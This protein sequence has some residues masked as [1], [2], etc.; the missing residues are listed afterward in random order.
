MLSASNLDIAEILHKFTGAGLDC[1]FLVPTQTGLEK[2]IMDATVSLQDYLKDEGIHDFGCQGQGPENKRLVN[3]VILS[4][5]IHV[6]TTTS[7]YRPNTK[8]GDSRIWFSKL[9]QLAEPSDLLAIIASDGR[10]VVINCTKSS[11]G[12]LLNDKD[13]P[14]WFYCSPKLPELS[15]EVQELLHL[16]SAVAKRGFVT[17]MRAGDTGVGYTLET[18]LGIA[19]NSSKSPDYKG[20]EIKSGRKKSADSGRTTIFSQVPFWSISRLKGS[21]DILRER[22]RFHEKKQRRQLFHEIDA[23]K[24]NSYGL[25]LVPDDKEGL[26]HQECHDASQRVRDASWKY[27]TLFQRLEEKHKQTFWVKAQTKDKGNAEQFWYNDVTYTSGVN[28]QK[29]PL[30]L[31]TGIISVDYTIKETPTGGAKDQG[32]LFKIRRSDLPLLFRSQVKLEL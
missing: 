31:E 8:N 12:S 29:L 5:G 14:L 27:E 21:A 6:E 13:S 7:L 9:R 20:I 16:M 1:R 28:P 10:L 15:I 19:A 32:Y 26:L 23:R 17:T 4:N 18:L 11:L 25:I 24:P 22:G 30:L 2:S 3:A